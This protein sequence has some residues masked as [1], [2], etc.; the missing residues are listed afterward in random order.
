MP[1]LLL[2]GCICAQPLRWRVMASCA[3]I[4]ERDWSEPQSRDGLTHDQLL[5]G[6]QLSLSISD[7]DGLMMH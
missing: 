5:M 7:G 1:V 4:A 3:M 2:D 6:K